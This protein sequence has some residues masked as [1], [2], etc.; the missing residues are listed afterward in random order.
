MATP[1]TQLHKLETWCHPVILLSLICH[2][3]MLT[4]FLNTSLSFFFNINFSISVA[5]SFNTESYVHFP[6]FPCLCSL[7][8]LLL[9]YVSLVLLSSYFIFVGKFTF[10]CALACM[11][12]SVA[13]LL[14]CLDSAYLCSLILCALQFLGNAKL[15]YSRVPYRF[16]HYGELL[17]I[18]KVQYE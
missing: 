15:F 14:S 5:Y 16:C 2:Q 10:F 12:T 11:I 7:L 1:C 4:L 17:F 3:V 18:R 6:W 8:H 9:S 13:S